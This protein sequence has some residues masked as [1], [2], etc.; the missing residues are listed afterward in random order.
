MKLV[1]EVRIGSTLPGMPTNVLKLYQGYHPVLNLDLMPRVI[2]SLKQPE[3]PN[4]VAVCVTRMAQI[5]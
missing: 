4:D 3:N 5:A 1:L 2:R